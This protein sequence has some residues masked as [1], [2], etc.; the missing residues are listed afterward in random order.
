M[1]KHNKKILLILGH[2]RKNSFCGALA[3]SYANGARKADHKIQTLYLEEM[4]FNLILNDTQKQKL[5]PCL[6]D[7][8][9]KINW[10]DHLIFVYP[11]W[12]SSMP[13]LLKG[14]VDRVFIS[15][16]AFKYK[17]KKIL[18]ARFL[19]GKTMR[20]IITMDTRP[21]LYKLFLG[22]IHKKEMRNLA[23]FCGIKS[24]QATY[25]GSIKFSSLTERQNWLKQIYKFGEKAK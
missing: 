10:A 20:L 2:P 24:P 9:E 22:N 3:E 12:W 21:W 16:F 11:T 13:A 14:F 4:N 17:E 25:L 5:E 8:Q 7:A 15:G 1:L 19:T 6:L 18:P 23:I